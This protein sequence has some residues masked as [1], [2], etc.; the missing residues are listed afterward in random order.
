MAERSKSIQK[1]TR[2]VCLNRTTEEQK[3]LVSWFRVLDGSCGKAISMVPEIG[4]GKPCY[5][6]GVYE[7]LPLWQRLYA[8]SSSIVKKN[9]IPLLISNPQHIYSVFRP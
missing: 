6:T 7:P 4:Y 1:E 3:E 9:Q 8:P 2:D 5:I